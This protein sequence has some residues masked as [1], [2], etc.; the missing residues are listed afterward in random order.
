MG[1]L[2]SVTLWGFLFNSRFFWEAVLMLPLS[3]LLARLGNRHL[4]VRGLAVIA[5]AIGPAFVIWLFEVAVLFV[6]SA[7]IEY[8]ILNPVFLY[9][10]AWD[11]L[12]PLSG[13]LGASIG[14]VTS[15][16]LPTVKQ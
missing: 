11:S 3:F 2:P 13:I 7:L 5:L 12:V 10:L 14:Y 4:R 1:R 8:K 15:R 9:W 16:R 6:S